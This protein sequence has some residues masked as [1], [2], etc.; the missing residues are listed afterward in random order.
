MVTPIG[1]HHGKSVRTRAAKTV[2]IARVLHRGVARRWE[3]LRWLQLEANPFIFGGMR[4][5]S[6]D[7]GAD[8]RYAPWI[9]ALLQPQILDASAPKVSLR[10]RAHQPVS[11]PTIPIRYLCDAAACDGLGKAAL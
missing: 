3:L 4:R 10:S 11:F 2:C 7:C 8:Y 6:T 1:M 9:D 5:N